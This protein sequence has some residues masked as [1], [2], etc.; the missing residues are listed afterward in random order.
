MNPRYVADVERL[1]L[2][3]HFFTFLSLEHSNNNVSKASVSVQPFL[4]LKQRE[5]EAQMVSFCSVTADSTS[6][7]KRLLCVCH[8]LLIGVNVEC[9]QP[10]FPQALLQILNPRQEIKCINALAF[11]VNLLISNIVVCFTIRLE[12]SWYTEI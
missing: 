10:V 1:G 6:E 2:A 9:L 11:A 7:S 4:L 8:D 5:H 12:R 3:P